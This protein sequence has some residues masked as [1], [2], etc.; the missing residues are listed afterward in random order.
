MKSIFCFCRAWSVLA[1]YFIYVLL[2]FLFLCPFV[3]YIWRT[4][5][6]VHVEEHYFSNFSVCLQV[7]EKQSYWKERP[8]CEKQIVKKTSCELL[9]FS[10]KKSDLFLKIRVSLAHFVKRHFQNYFVSRS[11]KT[12]LFSLKFL[13]KLRFLELYNQLK[14]QPSISFYYE[15]MWKI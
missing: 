6:H 12:R 15:E 8:F 7:E 14:I 10:V 3:R 11:W 1:N 5:A 9:S 2:R 4:L 13:L